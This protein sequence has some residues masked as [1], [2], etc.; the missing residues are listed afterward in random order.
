[1]Y[2]IS[3]PNAASPKSV[4]CSCPAHTSSTAATASPP[5]SSVTICTITC[6]SEILPEG[7]GRY[8]SLIAS[9]SLSKKSLIVCVYPVSSGPLIVMQSADLATSSGVQWKLPD[10]AAPQSTPQI[11]GTQVTGFVSCRRIFQS[12]STSS[13]AP[14][15]PR[16][17]ATSFLTKSWAFLVLFSPFVSSLVEAR[18][19]RVALRR[20][21]HGRERRE[22][23]GGW[24]R[25]RKKG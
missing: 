13:A 9:I 19:G 17:C 12:E 2:E 23:E 22:R 6:G 11:R 5:S 16:S 8:G 25:R 3:D 10:A 1:M 15:T 21:A 4:G 7:I 14:L 24:R 18:A 20:P